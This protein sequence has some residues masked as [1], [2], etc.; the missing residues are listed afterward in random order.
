[1]TACY[2]NSSFPV[3]LTILYKYADDPNK[4]V[5]ASANAGGENVNRGAVLGAVMGAYHGKDKWDKSL[6]EGLLYKK[7]YDVEVSEFLSKI[8]AVE[9]ISATKHSDL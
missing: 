6:L 3:L 8:P 1:M 2:V 4:A 7:A 5:L 9:A